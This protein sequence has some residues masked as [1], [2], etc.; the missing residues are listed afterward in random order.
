MDDPFS[1]QELDMVITRQANNKTPGTDRLRAELVKYLD[2]NNR[3]KLLININ[4]MHATGTLET[5]LH[6]ATIVSLYKKGDSSKLENYRPI[7][8]LQTFYKIIASLIKNRLAQGLEEWIMKTQYG[9][10]SG[11]STSHAMFMPRRLQDIAEKSGDNMAIV[12]LG[13]RHSTKLII[14][15]S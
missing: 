13:R 2:D 10:R 7:A 12:L 5:S 6:E 15:D 8:L 3:E 1:K 11:K 9:F 4:Q 14:L